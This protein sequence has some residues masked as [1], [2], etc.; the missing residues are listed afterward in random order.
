MICFWLYLSKL[1]EESDEQ[2]NGIFW[3]CN[4]DF[5][6][7]CVIALIYAESF[8]NCL[9]QL[10][11]NRFLKRIIIDQNFILFWVLTSWRN[12]WEWL[13]TLIYFFSL[14]VSLI[15]RYFTIK[16]IFYVFKKSLYRENIWA[17]P[18]CALSRF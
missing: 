15:R 7:P 18:L 1:D 5:N 2:Q 11:N 17:V 4:Q 10:A 8:R 16:P 14:C 3:A 9:L 12:D 6:W 13:I